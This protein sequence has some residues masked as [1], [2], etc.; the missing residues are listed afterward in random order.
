MSSGS[1]N[2]SYSSGTDL[3]VIPKTW[4]WSTL[5]FVADVRL[6]KML[7]PAAFAE[8]LHQLPYLRNENVRWGHIDLSDLKTM[9]FKD[10]ELERY[11]VK[12]GDLMI[13]EGGEAGRCAVYEGAAGTLMYQKALHRVRSLGPG[14]NQHFLQAVIQYYIFSHAVIPRASETTI[15]H[16]P[17]EKMQVLPVPIPPAGEQGRIVAAI[18]EQFTRLDAAVALLQHA[19]A[20]LKRYRS[21]VLKAAVEGRLVPTEA[22]LARVVDARSYEPADESLR[23]SGRLVQRELTLDGSGWKWI[24]EGWCRVTLEQLLAESPTNGRSVKDDSGGYRV[25]RLTALRDGRID[26]SQFKLGALTASEAQQFQVAEGD[27]FVSRGNGSLKFVGRG[28]LVEA[29]PSASPVAFPDTLIRVRTDPKIV[30]PGFLRAVW[31][32]PLVRSQIERTARTTAGIYKVNQQDLRRVLLPL[33]PLAEQQRIVAE[34]ERRMSGIEEME[35]AVEA[36]LNR[37]VRLRQS[38]L[39]R[40]FEG[41]LVRQDATDEPAAV[42]LERIRAERDATGTSTRRQ[43]QNGASRSTSTLLQEALPL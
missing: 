11:S 31:N 43:R 38:I 42:L 17:L 13:C 6:G 1:G 28:G 10:G 35:T 18:E 12:P 39:K 24:P 3:P 5:G 15:Q 30:N 40:A 36:N 41:A 7:S 29:D 14:L 37:T 9:G 21:T 2:S 23:A 33:P 4:E 19:R 20:N 32:G 22:E 27:F 16:L 26:L 34:V 8:G 25:L